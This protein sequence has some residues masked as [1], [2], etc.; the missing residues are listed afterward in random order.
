MFLNIARGDSQNCE[1][2]T[3]GGT[4]KGAGHAECLLRGRSKK[5]DKRKRR[6]NSYLH[7]QLRASSSAIP[8]H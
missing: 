8:P 2:Y 5:S 6:L 3:A 4:G 7:W 1:V